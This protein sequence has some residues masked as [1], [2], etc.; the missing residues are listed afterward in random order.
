MSNA[1]F[2]AANKLFS[3][4]LF[5]ALLV[6]LSPATSAAAQGQPGNGTAT[7][8][9]SQPKNGVDAGQDVPDVVSGKYYAIKDGKSENGEVGNLVSDSDTYF[10]HT[11]DEAIIKKLAAFEGKKV[12]LS[13]KLDEKEKKMHVQRILDGIQTT[14]EKANP[15]GL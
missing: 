10:V 14:V 11:S 9:P 6:A 13:G 12:G 1:R 2:S 7:P 5:C 8:P 15:R 3:A 4:A